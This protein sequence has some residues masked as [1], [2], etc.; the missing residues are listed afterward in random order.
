MSLIVFMAIA[1]PITAL[2]E[3][4]PWRQMRNKAQRRAQWKKK[5]ARL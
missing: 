5:T 2:I 1:A 3:G 4:V